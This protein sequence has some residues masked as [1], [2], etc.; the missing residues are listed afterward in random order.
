[1]KYALKSVA[2]LICI[3]ITFA[4]YANN[5]TIFDPYE[6]SCDCDTTWEYYGT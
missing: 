5:G 4:A 3:T 6:H 1:M 2:V